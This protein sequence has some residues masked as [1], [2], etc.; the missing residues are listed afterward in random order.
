MKMLL[1]ILPPIATILL[2]AVAGAGIVIDEQQT[3]EQLGGK[4]LTRARTV[5]I[6]GNRQKSIVDNG[7]RM[8]ITDLD[9]GV[10][11]MIDSVRKAYVEFPF[12]PNGGG[13][14]A[15]QGPV[16][17]TISFKKTG[18]RATII[19]YSCDEYTGAGSVGPN[20]VSMSGCFSDSAPGAADYG[21]FQREMA[22]KVKGTPMAN[23]GE[24]PPGVPLRLTITTTLSG[25]SAAAAPAGQADKLNQ[26]LSH[27]QIT[28]STTVSSISMKDLPAD[29]FEVPSGYQKEQL[30]PMGGGAP[31]ASPPSKV[32]E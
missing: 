6:E 15:M 18:G 1:S 3:L 27:P 19:G 20:P 2:A 5:E 17:P 14:A 31:A 12:P 13:P 26:M 16:S 23:M 7:K 29:S 28:T 10:M 21:K 30:P 4:K 11:V 32:P 22:D 8:V 9:K 25:H 24:M